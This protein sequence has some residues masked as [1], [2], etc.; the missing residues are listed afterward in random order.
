MAALGGDGSWCVF[1]DRDG[2]LNDHVERDGR[3]SSPRSPEEWIPRPDASAALG[4]LRAAGGRLVVI[5]NQPDL[6]RGLLDPR[7]LDGLHRALAA[8]AGVDDVFVCPHRAAD[9]CA[10][11]KPSSHWLYRAARRHRLDLHLSYLVGDRPTDAQAGLN[12]GT[13]AVLLTTIRRTSNVPGLHY[14]PDLSAAATEILRHRAGSQTSRSTLA[15]SPR[16]E[17]HH[18]IRHDSRFLG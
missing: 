10:C 15:L 13:R 16:E 12:A 4:R 5:T 8:E 18:G 7:A 3:R 1:F 2:T 9:S 14:A 6:S 11:R 17:K